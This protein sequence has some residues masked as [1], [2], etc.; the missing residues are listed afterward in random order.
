MTT[1]SNV[2]II[3]R[4]LSLTLYKPDE[5]DTRVHHIGGK[6]FF[7]KLESLAIDGD[8]SLGLIETLLISLKK[9]TSLGNEFH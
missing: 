2:G 9:L 7:P 3:C 8:V 4:Q 5:I 1:E 6:D